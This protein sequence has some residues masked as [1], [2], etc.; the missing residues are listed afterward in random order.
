MSKPAV[1]APA[2]LI[3][4]QR[5]SVL[6]LRLNRPES[7]NAIDRKLGFALIAAIAEAADEKV[8]RAIVLTGTGRAFCAG[9]DIAGLQAFLQGDAHHAS[10]AVDPSDRNTLYLRLATAMVRC[11][12]PIIAAINGVAFG[13]GTEVLCAA[14]L[15]CTARSARIGSG[16]AKIGAVGNAAFLGAV[17]GS[18][19]AFEIYVSGRAVDAAEAL[20]IG[21][22][23]YVFDDASF[24]QD[25]N[26]LAQRIAALPTRV[27]ALQKKLRNDC[28][29][30]SL[31]QR[32]LMQEEAHRV[33]MNQFEDAR[34]GATAFIEKRAPRFSGR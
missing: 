23:N 10:A 31:E 21:L 34:E 27:V 24:A 5:D 1:D 11:P 26:E 22:V 9:D 6:W 17:I 18:A 33:C 28:T 25:V 8:V 14:D 32:A 4:E 13:A 29:G 12:K 30:H 7:L 19:R 16:L 2:P 15:R 20:A 3:A